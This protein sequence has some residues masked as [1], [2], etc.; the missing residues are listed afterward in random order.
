MKGCFIFE[1]KFLMLKNF[2][3]CCFAYLIVL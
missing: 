1:K 2:F 3:S